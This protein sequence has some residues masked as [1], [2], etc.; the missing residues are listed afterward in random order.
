MVDVN[1]L[2]AEIIRNG[3]TQKEIA[4]KLGITPKT[5]S[6]RLKRKV[7]GSDEIELLMELLNIA[8]PVPIFFSKR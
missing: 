8:N 5:F 2:K 1:A 3:Y 7:L 6:M 4:Q